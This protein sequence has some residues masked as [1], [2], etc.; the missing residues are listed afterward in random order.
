MT[1]RRRQHV[2]LSEVDN[3][4]KEYLIDEVRQFELVYDK[5]NQHYRNR[6]RIITA[7]A[8]I[9]ANLQ[10]STKLQVSRKSGCFCVN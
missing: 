3:R 8:N 9:A 6:T 7:W 10:A 1:P 4:L 5:K 2:I